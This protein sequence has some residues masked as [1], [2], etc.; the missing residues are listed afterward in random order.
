MN[1]KDLVLPSVAALLEAGRNLT[2]TTASK[3]EVLHKYQDQVNAR[4]RVYASAQSAAFLSVATASPAEAKQAKK[5]AAPKAKK[6]AAPKAD[7]E[8]APAV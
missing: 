7:T 6:A 8:P 5:A 2:P 4:R 1:I 3:A